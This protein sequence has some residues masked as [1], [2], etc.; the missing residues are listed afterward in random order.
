[1]TKKNSKAHETL[2]LVFHRDGVPP[3]MTF[4]GSKEQTMADFKC[5]LREA[6]CHG[7][8]TE[9]YS[10]WQQAAKGYT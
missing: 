10:P 3:T 9:P 1:M 6:D 2:S 5:K 8:L 4:N 7:R